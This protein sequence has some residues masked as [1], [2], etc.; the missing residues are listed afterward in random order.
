ME[1]FK[2]INVDDIISCEADD[3]Y[4]HLHLKNKSKITASRTLKEIQN[5]LGEYEYFI[6]IHHSYLINLNEVN[7]YIRGEGGY[8]IMNDGSHL[9][10]SRNKKETLLKYL[11]KG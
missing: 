8:V 3:N 10:V 2:L 1:G 7:Q 5:L 9:S 11:I 4:T 6:R